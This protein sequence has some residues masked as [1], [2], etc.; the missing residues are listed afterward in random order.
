[1][2]IQVVNMKYTGQLIITDLA[3]V[4]ESEEAKDE[5]KPPV[6]LSFASSYVLEID[7]LTDDG[8]NLRMSK[9]NPFT[10]EAMFQVAF[11]LVTTISEPKAAIVEAYTNRLTQDEKNNT[12]DSL[13][14]GQETTEDSK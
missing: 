14:D 9:W 6:C 5:G 2:T 10:D 12:P 11:D 4:W 3:N 8:Y 7:S 1:M 13:K